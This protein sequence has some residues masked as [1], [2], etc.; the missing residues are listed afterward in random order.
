MEILKILRFAL[1]LAAAALAGFA[2][3]LVIG[4]Q[5][6]T[7]A[8]DMAERIIALQS[9]IDAFSARADDLAVNGA[10]PEDL[11]EFS[12]TGRDLR[13]AAAALPGDLASSQRVISEIAT[14]EEHVTSLGGPDGGIPESALP[15]LSQRQRLT[16]LA[17]DGLALDM[18]VRELL[19]AQSSDLLGVLLRAIWGVSALWLI[20]L[21]LA[22]GLAVF[23]RH[24]LVGPLRTIRS[25]VERIEKGDLS[26]RAQ[27]GGRDELA[28]LADGINDMAAGREATEARLVRTQAIGRLG[29][30]HLDARSGTLDW[31]DQTCAIFE[32][33]PASFTRTSQEFLS[34]IPDDDRDMVIAQRKA[35]RDSATP[36]DFQHRIRTGSGR[37]KWVWE[38]AEVIRDD[39]GEVICL[40]GTV[41]DITELKETELALEEARARSEH[42]AALLR[43][44]GRT[45]RFGG[46]RALPNGDR[47]EWTPETAAI[48]EA[49]YDSPPHVEDAMAYYDPADRPRIRAL[50]QKCLRDGEDF[51]DVF[52]FTTATGRRLWVRSSGEAVRDASG[53][54]TELRGAF[55]D[56]TE[57]FEARDEAVRR[58][59]ELDAV[60]SAMEDGFVS[61]DAAGIVSFINPMA[62]ELLGVTEDHDKGLRPGKALTEALAQAP[63][64]TL[65]AQLAAMIADGTAR[66]AELHDARTDRWVGILLHRTG[67]RTAILLRDTTAARQADRRLRV[68]EAALEEID[69]IVLITEAS[70]VDGPDHPRIL[71]ANAAFGRVTGHAPEQAIGRTPRFLQGPETSR[72]EL[73]RVREALIRREPVQAELINYDAAGRPLLM[74][75]E[76]VPLPDPYGGDGY[77]VAVQRDI[78]LQK[79]R[80]ESEFQNS[81][82]VVVGQLTGGVAHDFNNLLTII[83]G[84]ADL[85]LDA[86][87]APEKRRLVEA[88]IDAAERGARLTDSLLAFSRRTPLEPVPTDVNAFLDEA[89]TLLRQ[90]LPAGVQMTYVKGAAHPVVDIDPSRLQAAL[91]NLVLNGRDAVGGRGQIT[92]ETDDI[93]LD[94]GYAVQHGD[95]A[96]G[97]YVLLSVTDDGAGMDAE[98]AAQAFEP[99]FTTKAVG[100]GTGLGLSSVYGFARQSGGQA[101]INSEAGKGT[102]VQLYLPRAGQAPALS[103]RQT[104][105]R[106]SRG[107]GEHILV[108]EDD[109]AVLEYAARQLRALGYR[110]TVAPDSAQA[111]EVLGRQGDDIDLLFTDVVLGG[112]ASGKALADR[113]R[114]DRP[115]L[116]VLFTSGYTNN[117]ITHD[118][119]LDPDVKLL[120]KPYRGARLA[121]KL[122]EALAG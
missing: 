119:R 57:L 107:A 63:E 95:L 73:D 85:L 108:V 110:V 117:A 40:D 84:N 13:A 35:L 113:A 121:Q 102:T 76:I 2:V 70:H 12:Q 80:E 86:V 33:D 112:G 5:R 54:I 96:P 11:A 111:L 38:R 88:L 9:G 56:V 105:E 20:F 64:G 81:K 100:A 91:V 36:Y 18:Q 29:G 78:T 32:V 51:D 30:W 46:W 92:V 94:A 49:P 22:T 42:G 87:E 89:E 90:A 99:F 75:I 14:L 44:A 34:R 52:R 26:A 93:Y 79:Q 71:Y 115:S 37:I 118:G 10:T 103:P 24:R 8:E 62:R 109:P 28:A 67:G 15:D 116:R 6:V 47:V 97:D 114:A 50:F 66:E 65:Q 25:T 31:D 58:N 55:Q 39:T 43:F 106:P 45:A 82:M 21:G 7:H 104:L 77:F 83:M 23:L 98:T 72:K 19:E 74:R 3:A 41:Q 69:D 120:E 68:L 53:R 60:V 1:W 48:H 59:A 16:A 122:R 4:H 61:L 101:Q 17:R 27:V